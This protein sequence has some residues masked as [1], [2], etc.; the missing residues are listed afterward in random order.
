[1]GFFKQATVTTS[2]KAIARL[3]KIIWTLIFGGLLTLIIGL[4]ALKLDS[5]TGWSLVLA[6]ALLAVAGVVLIYVRSKMKTE[7]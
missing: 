1:V 4:S 6:G 2:N 7:V 3:H 5:I